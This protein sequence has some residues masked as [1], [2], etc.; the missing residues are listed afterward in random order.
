MKANLK[1]ILSLAVLGMTLLAST[2]PAQAGKVNTAGGVTIGSTQSMYWASGSM[3][4]ARYGAGGSQFIGCNIIAANGPSDE[5]VVTC[6]ATDNTNHY[7]N[8]GSTNPKFQEVIQGM[9]DSSHIYFATASNGGPCTH[10]EA[11]HGSDMLK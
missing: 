10:I 11:Y 2:A 5:Y 7:L 3:V 4:G 1:N 8:C 6:A 9:T